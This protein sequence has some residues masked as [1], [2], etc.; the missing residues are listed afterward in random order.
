MEQKN[1]NKNIIPA[2]KDRLKA[3]WRM[4]Y[5]PQLLNL[6]DRSLFYAM[7]DLESLPELSVD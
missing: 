4:K 1:K 6:E 3:F 2:L 7:K 5:H